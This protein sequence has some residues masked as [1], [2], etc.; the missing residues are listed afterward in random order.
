ME[1]KISNQKY[2]NVKAIL[3]AGMAFSVLYWIYFFT[4]GFDS[5]GVSV[6]LNAANGVMPFI[7]FWQY[8][9]KYRVKGTQ[10]IAWNTESIRFK[11]PEIPKT[12]V[13][14]NQITAITIRLDE[15][16][17]ETEENSWQLNLEDYSK[18][19]DRM[20]VK[21]FFTKLQGQLEKPQAQ[22]AA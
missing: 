9:K 19:E 15:I 13:P 3:I 10:F 16:T 11:T 21:N 5:E 1:G 12:E 8:Q 18:Y 17:L 2:Q 4:I 7:L 6:Y 22:T 20:A 14:L